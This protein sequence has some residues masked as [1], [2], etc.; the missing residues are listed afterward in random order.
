[1]PHGVTERLRDLNARE[2]VAVVPL[3]AL[4]L[5]IG[6]YPRPLLERVEPT[7]KS[8][9]AHFEA[10]TDYREP[11]QSEEEAPVVEREPRDEEPESEEARP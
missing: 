1:V 9:I 5:F 2:L 10:R 7:M 3:L 6:L 8:L 4:S 11:K